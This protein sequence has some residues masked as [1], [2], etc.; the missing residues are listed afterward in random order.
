MRTS[1]FIRLIRLNADGGDG[2]SMTGA[3]SEAPQGDSYPTPA[4]QPDHFS[5]EDH[6]KLDTI[7]EEHD[8]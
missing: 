5:F 3:G 8:K 2:G 4:A 6:E 7:G 1:V